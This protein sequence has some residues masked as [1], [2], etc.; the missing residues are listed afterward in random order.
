M[1]LCLKSAFKN[2]ATSIRFTRH[3]NIIAVRSLKVG[4]SR[5]R[6]DENGM[7]HQN[8]VDIMSRIHIVDDAT[9]S[10]KIVQ[11]ILDR[12]EPV[13][14]DAEVCYYYNE[15]LINGHLNNRII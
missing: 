12:G 9:Q 1:A 15:D 14:V 6:H 13:A 8:N 11:S 10:M 4:N 7:S 5:L 2:T 3:P